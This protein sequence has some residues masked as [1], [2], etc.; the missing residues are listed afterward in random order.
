MEH[1]K[2]KLLAEKKVKLLKAKKAHEILK[3]K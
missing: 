2:A 3:K 1:S